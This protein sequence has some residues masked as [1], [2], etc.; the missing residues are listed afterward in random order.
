MAKSLAGC[1]G[2]VSKIPQPHGGGKD[3]YHNKQRLFKARKPPY[4][5]RTA[6]SITSDSA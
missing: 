1:V 2:T 6:H 5:R 3:E 4:R